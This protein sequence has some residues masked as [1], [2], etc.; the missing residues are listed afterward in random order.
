MKIQVKNLGTIKQGEIA[1]DKNLIVL[2][3]PNHSGKSYIAYLIYG[4]LKI[5]ENN[6]SNSLYDKY[7]KSLYQYFDQENVLSQYMTE[8]GLSINRPAF[9][10]ENAERYH[11][12]H[13]QVLLNSMM[14]V[15]ASKELQPQIQLAETDAEMNCPVVR[16]FEEIVQRGGVSYRCQVSNEW[17]ELVSDKHQ[18]RAFSLIK[19]YFY[20]AFVDANAFNSYFFPAERSALNLISNE[21][22]KEKALERDDLATQINAG[23]SLERIVKSLQKK[24]AFVPRYPLPINDYM[25]FIN[26]LIYLRKNDSDY[27]N[28]AQEI[29]KTLMHGKV[30]VTKHGELQFKPNKLRK[31]LPLHLASSLVKSLAGLVVYFRYLARENDVIII[32]EPELNLHPDNQRRIA[33]I[34]AKAANVGFKM[35]LSTH[36]SYI[37]KEFNNLI[38]LS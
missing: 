22:V 32:D 35:I 9:F 26:D 31:P 14:E 3:G 28:F 30:L 11:R 19:P 34:L 15:F 29:E 2:A 27:V 10:K 5:K 13:S 16:E 38:M 36:S 4:L 1:L 33:K 20:E 12:I 6:A 18:N 7:K 24:L 25:Y 23:D 37:I 8:K 17:F 21:V